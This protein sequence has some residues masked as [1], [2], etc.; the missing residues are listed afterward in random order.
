[1]INVQFTCFAHRRRRTT[2]MSVVYFFVLKWINSKCQSKQILV[3]SLFLKE[4]SL[5][6]LL[7]CILKHEHKFPLMVYVSINIIVYWSWVYNLYSFKNHY[8]QTN[9]EL[10][11]IKFI[12]SNCLCLLSLLVNVSRDFLYSPESVLLWSY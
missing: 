11:N 8:F 1:M 7:V 6:D 4:M 9:L 3:V 10:Y 12:N 5:N 2:T